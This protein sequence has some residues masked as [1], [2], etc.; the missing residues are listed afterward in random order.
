[1]EQ[2]LLCIYCVELGLKVQVDGM[3][4]LSCYNPDIYWNILDVVIVMS[5]VIDTWVIGLLFGSTVHGARDHSSGKTH[6]ASNSGQLMMLMR[7]LRL[8]RILRLAKL[9]KA[10]RPLYLLVASIMA[11]LEG[12]AWVFV[13][14]LTLLYAMAIVATRLA[15]HGLIWP[16]GNEPEEIMESFRTV[17]DSMFTLFRLMTGMPS[18]A[19]QIAVDR[20]MDSL[21]FTRFFFIFFIISSTWTL[22]STLTAVISENMITT[23]EQQKQ[24]L[25][26]A[27]AD[28]DHENRILQLREL[29]DFMAEGCAEDL[30]EED[31]A[32]F[33]EN[34]D[35]AARVALSC[36]VTVKETEA[37]LK[38]LHRESAVVTK[39]MFVHHLLNVSEP[40]TEKT[41]LQ[42]EARLT[43]FQRRTESVL[44]G[45]ASDQQQHSKLVSDQQAF[46][47][48][49]TGSLDQ[50]VK[51]SSLDAAQVCTSLRELL[52]GQADL[53]QRVVAG[54]GDALDVTIMDL[55]RHRAE[56]ASDATPTRESASTCSMNFEDLQSSVDEIVREAGAG[57]PKLQEDRRVGAVVNPG[58]QLHVAQLLARVDSSLE[59]HRLGRCR[60]APTFTKPTTE[61][62]QLH[63]RGGVRAP[64]APDLSFAKAVQQSAAFPDADAAACALTARLRS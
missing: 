33:L 39:D 40:C 58:R 4:L 21:P 48:H 42:L 31:L 34:K 32:R 9:V 51:V 27:S 14:T 17:A 47:Q 49:V 59:A 3:K 2:L 45:L 35:Y 50:M 10:V 60:S 61:S 28:E 55:E 53:K 18:E 23:S 15:G 57:R 1:M 30:Q 54:F 62:G 6:H 38:A 16:N 26:L 7:M 43:E 41:I 20:L 12:V 64:Q 22:L 19:E 44:S 24:E 36:R 46:M 56:A 37:V 5:A 52:Q 29:F 25:A 63:P 11:A 13:L 8:L